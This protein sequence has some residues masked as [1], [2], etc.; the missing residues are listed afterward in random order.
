MKL[1]VVCADDYAISEPVSKAIKHLAELK[2]ISATSVM[3]LSPLW[4]DHSQELLAFKGLIDVGLHLDWTSEFALQNGH[5]NPLNQL[6]LKAILQ[7]LSIDECKKII[8]QQLDLFEKYWGQG[9]DFI[10]GHQHIQ[11]FNGIRQALI[12]VV[13]ERYQQADSNFKLKT[14][15]LRVSQTISVQNNLKSKII[16]FMGA[17]ALTQI[18]S[19]ENIPYF[20]YLSGIYNLKTGSIPYAERM[21]KWL[22]Q[23]PNQNNSI[24]MCHP[25]IQLESNDFISEARVHEYQY[26]KSDSFLQD[27]NQYNTHITATCQTPFIHN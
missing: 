8:H 13:K 26:L 6:M 23:L 9:P 11:Q 27:L 2:R 7:Q 3:S 21:K 12:E 5:G 10:D 18:A 20:L 24:L 1:L 25:S 15:Y 22:E 16:A 19:K 4:P 14:P 17:K